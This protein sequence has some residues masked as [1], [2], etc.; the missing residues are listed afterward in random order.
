MAVNGI[1]PEEIATN[2]YYIITKISYSENGIN[3][4]YYSSKAISVN[5]A[6]PIFSIVGYNFSKTSYTQS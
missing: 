2:T 6:P 4:I 3:N 5:Y 1:I